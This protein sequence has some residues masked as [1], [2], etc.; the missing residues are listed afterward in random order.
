[1]EFSFNK[2]L[3]KS[4]EEYC[5]TNN[6]DISEY[7]ND[8]IEKTHFSHVYGEQPGFIKPKQEK[9]VLEPETNN[10]FF[11]K[12]PEM[13]IETVPEPTVNNNGI[14]IVEINR[15]QKVRTLK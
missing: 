7:L 14:Q 1:M 13:P 8:L 9:P 5:A 6:L 3:L 4:I 15:K 10:V 2:R 11:E 12:E